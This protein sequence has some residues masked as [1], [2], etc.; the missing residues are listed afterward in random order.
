MNDDLCPYIDTLRRV[1]F[2]AGCVL[3]GDA[4]SDTARRCIARY[5]G[6]RSRLLRQAPGV[7]RHVEALPRDATA[8]AIRLTARDAAMHLRQA[9]ASCCA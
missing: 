5:N 2:D 4:S 1:A 8:G 7:A 3:L 9:T 6:V